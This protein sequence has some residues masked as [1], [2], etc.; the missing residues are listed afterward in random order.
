VYILGI[1]ERYRLLVMLGCPIEW[2]G[3]RPARREE[4]GSMWAATTRGSTVLTCALARSSGPFRL[5]YG[6]TVHAVFDYIQI[7]LRE[8]PQCGVVPN[9]VSDPD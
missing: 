3:A 2:R 5:R 8:F 6:S 9:G 4:G 1:Q 7:S